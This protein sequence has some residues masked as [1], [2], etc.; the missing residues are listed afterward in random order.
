MKLRFLTASIATPARPLFHHGDIADDSD[1]NPSV[2]Q[3]IKLSVVKG[4]DLWWRI[5]PLGL[6]SSGLGSWSNCLQFKT[7]KPVVDLLSP[8]N[9]EDMYPW[10]VKLEWEREPGAMEY[11][12]QLTVND[13][14]FEPIGD[15]LDIPVPQPVDLNSDVIYPINVKAIHSVHNVIHWWQAFAVG[16]GIATGRGTSLFGVFRH[17]FGAGLLA[18]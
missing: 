11:V 17:A 16:S 12:L 14:Q 7:L 10:P 4:K 3:D 15:P 18:R 5:R 9:E 1:G 8:L 13:G 6:E 2:V